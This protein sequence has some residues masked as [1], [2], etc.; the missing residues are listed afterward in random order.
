MKTNLTFECNHDHSQHTMTCVW[1][2]GR[3]QL[4]YN[5]VVDKAFL[6]VDGQVKCSYNRLTVAEFAAQQAECQRVAES[7]A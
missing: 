5:F 2:D 3:V 1:R 4:V 6:L 7:L